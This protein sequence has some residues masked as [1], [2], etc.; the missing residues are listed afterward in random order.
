[1]LKK[2]I[3][4]GALAER[5]RRLLV[6][7]GSLRM[8]D[9]RWIMIRNAHRNSSSTDVWMWRVSVNWSTER[10]RLLSSSLPCV[11][12]THTLS[13]NLNSNVYAKACILSDSVLVICYKKSDHTIWISTQS[14]R[15]G[16]CFINSPLHF[17]ACFR[18]PS[19]SEQLIPHGLFIGQRR[20]PDDPESGDQ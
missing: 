9:R 5:W 7:P 17:L 3:P 6:Y 12:H 13:L 4:P 2:Q 14:R 16:C 11:T 18:F 1:M 19:N 15:C 20:W 10:Y 8:N